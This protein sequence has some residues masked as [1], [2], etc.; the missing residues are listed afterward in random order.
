MTCEAL[1]TVRQQMTHK[2]RLKRMI[3]ARALFQAERY[4]CAEH[5]DIIDR[6]WITVAGNVTPALAADLGWP[7]DQRC[8]YV[9][10]P[11]E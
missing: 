9:E 7:K 2:A 4:L 8:E 5:A 3:N 10:D 11:P 6:E 1:A